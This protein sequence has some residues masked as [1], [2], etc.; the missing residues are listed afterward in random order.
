[1][2][3]ILVAVILFLLIAPW[4][5]SGSVRAADSE[6]DKNRLE[7][8]YIHE[9]L[10]PN[11]IYGSWNSYYLKYYRFESPTFNWFVH[12][13]CVDR[14]E[15]NDYIGL[16]G[17][18]HDWTSRFYTYSVVA[19]G[20]KVDYLPKIR[21]DHDFNFKF[22]ARRNLIWTIG[23]TYID[24]HTV[25]RDTI[26]SSGL[27]LYENKWIFQYRLFRNFSHPGNIKSWT[28]LG[29]VGYGQEK[30]HWTFVTVSQGSQAYL[31]QSII[32][33]EEIRQTAFSIALNHRHWL[34]RRMG[35]FVD[36]SYLNLKNAYKKYGVS[37]GLFVDF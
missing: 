35:V 21:I 1:M 30:Y 22:G 20:T 3:R 31:A 28:H 25:Y 36:L 19:M 6:N 15:K 5:P 2:K 11:D 10:E 8:Q 29:S 37:A 26:I 33:P 9:R 16:A 17:F 12:F 18:A 7:F 32:T 24:Y 34:T 23:G 4:L 27:M 14:E 13:G